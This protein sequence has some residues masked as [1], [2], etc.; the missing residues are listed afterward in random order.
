ME[1]DSRGA[2]LIELTRI[3]ALGLEAREPLASQLVGLVLN[4]R[5]LLG[6]KVDA[7]HSAILGEK[8][9]RNALLKPVGSVETGKEGMAAS[10]ES[11]KMLWASQ[12]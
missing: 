8:G 9:R 10:P 1:D 4:N 6:L 2:Q 3:K 11:W 12:T 5:T 7:K